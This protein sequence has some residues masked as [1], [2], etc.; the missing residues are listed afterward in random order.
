MF[1]KR[2]P[3]LVLLLLTVSVT[4]QVIEKDSAAMYKKRRKIL[5]FGVGGL[6][7]GST[8]MLY[9]LWYRD[10][11]QSP[12]H[13]TN[14]NASWMHMDKIG[15]F[16]TTYQVG[17]YGYWAMRWAGAKRKTAIWFGGS[18][19]LIYNTTVEIFD[20]MSAEWGFSPGDMVANVLGTG[21]FISQQLLWD[22]QR[23]RVKFSYHPTEFPQYRPDLL[24][25]NWAQSILKDYNGQ[26]YW[27]SVNI[28]SFLPEKAKFPG[29]INISLGYAAT[30]M[31]GAKSNPDEI[32]GVPLPHFDR[33]AQYY[34]SADI[35]WKRIK[36]D[37]EF[38]R[39]VFEV[40]SF[41]KIPFPALEYNSKEG[42]VFHPVYF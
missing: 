11:E 5:I 37:S 34:L 17:S 30:G 36:T 6:Y 40:I 33:V 39:F 41:I 31:I 27:A 4:A 35:D 32:D 24:G 7:V 10:Y 28:K 29:W 12:L 21:F 18:W 19:G 15:H 1:K 9:S 8:A 22:E 14:D 3:V 20:G 13:L 16:Q 23:I 25:S 2:L 26:T 42:F 38:L